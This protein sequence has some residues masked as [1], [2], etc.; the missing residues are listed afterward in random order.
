MKVTVLGSGTSSGVPTIGCNCPACTSSDPRDNRLRASVM[1]ESGKSRIVIDTS[2]DFR[3]QMLR[4]NVSN[5]DAVLFT[6]YHFDHIGGFDDLRGLNFVTH[7]SI[8]VYADE[9]TFKHIKRAFSYA[10]ETPEQLGGGVPK[11]DVNFIDDKDFVIKDINIQPLHL[12]H[13][14][15][16]VLGFRIGSFAYCTDTNFIPEE[17]Y[18]KIQNLDILIIDALRYHKH[19]THFT[20]EEALKEIEKIKPKK[21]YLTHIAHQILHEECEKMLPDNVKLCYDGLII[22]M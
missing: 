17:T 19:P 14:I 20:V 9:K 2:P 10:F 1:I 6:H 4:H 22:E 16:N 7:K 18:G 15:L 3:Q 11:T 12:K 21:A 5:V 13:G 8:P